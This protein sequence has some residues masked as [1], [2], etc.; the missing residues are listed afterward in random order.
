[1]HN[2]YSLKLQIRSSNYSLQGKG[3]CMTY[4]TQSLVMEEMSWEK[5]VYLH[6]PTLRTRTEVMATL[7]L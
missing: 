1:M 6:L 5:P 7:L 4:G 3:I 2:P